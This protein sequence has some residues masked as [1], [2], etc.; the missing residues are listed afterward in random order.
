MKIKHKKVAASGIEVALAGILGVGALLQTSVSVQASSAMMPGIEEIVSEASADKPFKILEIVDD[1]QDAEIG[2]YVSGQEPYI[3]LYSYTYT[4]KDENNTKQEK[5]IHFSSLKEGLQKLPDEQSRKE[6]AMNVKLNEAGEIDESASTGIKD[7]RSVCGDSAESSPLS[8]SEY[9]EKYFLSNDDNKD[10]WKT[11]D[12]IEVETGETRIDT[13]TLT[14]TYQENSAGTGNYTK[15]EQEYY[16]IRKGNSSDA[17]RTDKYRENIQNFYYSDG[18][19]NGAP[20]FLEFEP[21]ENSYINNA[22]DNKTQNET[23]GPEYDYSKG[24]YGYY[25]NVYADLTEDMVTDIGNNKYTFPGENP[26]KISNFDADSELVQEYISTQSDAFSAGEENEFSSVNTGDAASASTG[27]DF[28]SG[29]SDGF[30]DGDF[31]TGENDGIDDV[32]GN[33]SVQ[34]T[35]QGSTSVEAAS[36][37]IVPDMEDGTA[38]QATILGRIDNPTAQTQN[39]QSDPNVYIGENIDEY[40]YYKYTLVGD[41]EYIKSKAREC[42]DSDKAAQEA[43][44]SIQRQ[45]GDITI[46]NGQYW[47]WQEKS[48]KSD[49]E[50][51]TLSVVTGR[52][53]VAYSDIKKIDSRVTENY[54]YRVTKVYFCCINKDSG[55]K[56]DDFQYFGWYYPSYPQN[57][58]PYIKVNQGEKATHYISEA[59]Y[60]LTPGKG[61]YD[62]VPGGEQ[63]NSVEV[64]HIY[65]KGGYKNNDWFKRYVFHLSPADSDFDNF[66]IEVDTK[67]A[68]KF[69]TEYGNGTAVASE[70]NTAAAAGSEGNSANENNEIEDSNSEDS[71]DS[72]TNEGGVSEVAPMTSEAGVELVSIE[73]EINDSQTENF[74]D[75]TDTEMNAEEMESQQAEVSVNDTQDVEFSDGGDDVTDAFSAGN[76][77]NTIAV[78]DLADYDLIYINSSML[79]KASMT[80]IASLASTKKLPCIINETKLENNADFAEAFSEFI[81][82]EDADKHYV[83]TCVYF[84][85]NTLQAENPSDLLNVLFDTNFNPDVEEGAY[86]NADQTEGFE[87]IIKYIEKENKYREIG[88][89]TISDGSQTDENGKN[90]NELSKKLSQ[91]RA[92]EYIINYKYKRNDMPTGEIRVLE[93]QPARSSGKITNDDVLS[94]LGYSNKITVSSCCN[95]VNEIPDN[96]LNKNNF[97]WHSAYASGDKIN[98][99]S[100]HPMHWFKMEFEKETDIDGF[101]YIARPTGKNGILNEYKVEFYDKNG[102]L[103]ENETQTGSMGY[104]WYNIDRSSK[105]IIFGNKVKNVKSMKIIFTKT[106]GDSHANVYATASYIAPVWE[107]PEINITTMTTSEFVGHIDD[108]NTKYDMVYLGDDASDLNY[109]ANFRPDKQILYYHIGGSRLAK[110][111]LQGLMNHDYVINSNGV[112]VANKVGDKDESTGTLVGSVRGSGND[113]TEQ[114]KNKLVDFAKSGYPVIVAGDIYDSNKSISTDLVDNS[115]YIYDFLNEIKGYDNVYREKDI[116]KEDDIAFYAELPKPK[117]EFASENGKPVSAIGTSDGPSG[118]YMSGDNITFNFQIIDEAQASPANASYDCE[119]Y[120]DL[121]CDGNYSKSEKLKD[122]IVSKDGEVV[123]ADEDGK[124]HLSLKT[125]YTVS[126]K[127]PEEYIKLMPWKLVVTNNSNSEIRTSETGYTKRQ[128]TSAGNNTICVLQ[129][130]PNNSCNWTLSTDTEFKNLFN[131]V[132]EDFDV[133]IEAVTISQYEAS[134]RTNSSYLD[135][136]NMLIIGFCDG[137]A[138]GQDLGNGGNNFSKNGAQ[139]IL[140]F[141]NTGKSVIFAHDNTSSSNI[142]RDTNNN[143]EGGLWTGWAYYFNKI[144][145]SVSG[146]DRYGITESE[147][148]EILKGAKILE[149]GTDDWNIISQN[150]YDMAYELGSGKTKAYSETQGFS[151]GKLQIAIQGGGSDTPATNYVT[152]INEGAISEYPYKID[153]TFQ[154]ANTH[155]QYYQL[156]MEED[157]DHDGSSD[158]V[159]WYC[160]GNNGTSTSYYDRTPNDVRNNYYIYSYK[161][162]IYTGVGHS[163]GITSMEKKLF[164]NTIIAAYNA[165]AVNP[166]LSFVKSSDWN[167]AQEKSVYYMLD[168]VNFNESQELVKDS[169]DFHLKVTDSNLVGT[170]INGDATKDLKLE[171]FIESDSVNAKTIDGIGTNTRVEKIEVPISGGQLSTDAN[172]NTYVYSG[173]V[174]DFTLGNL[175]KYL[176][177]RTEEFR[178]KTALYARISCKYLYYGVEKEA[179][180]VTKIDI[181]Q[182]QLFDMD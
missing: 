118:N 139:R 59:E 123:K 15:G 43:G 48:D 121:N 119:L 11:A 22:I 126:R 32:S 36:D 101:I 26:A 13:V 117:I 174:Y 160:L 143:S 10:E 133:Q 103:M 136:Y 98:D 180:S 35:E 50:K 135:A 95:H 145:R 108:V 149:S 37:V 173:N 30:S 127:V 80:E 33:S 63:I 158:I 177:D 19:E 4:Y 28:G 111:E 3:K 12:F 120:I 122:I 78:S 31:S 54:Y 29:Q 46:E 107:E 72:D 156:A 65:Y 21:V 57:E 165:Q 75:G 114:I 92:I 110:Y 178:G 106:F 150:T 14:G 6:F 181:C 146:M 159:V 40:P 84:F 129:I 44:Q 115:S 109:D 167:A 105:K 162:V 142:D 56:S 8:M 5:T 81:N 171:L 154:V 67:T 164:V 27:S 82:N 104:D 62:F 23:I 97:I 1:T 131:A 172:G 86:A 70:E 153:S 52:Q 124:Y 90:K 7:I 130:T 134:L 16:P 87:E 89:D 169:Q 60:K 51:I 83:N 73:N 34:T 138:Y 41:L 77:D 175:Q 140:D 166:E 88:G 179:Q 38:E 112:K 91:S 74:Q 18:E 45:T 182:R 161:N 102:D 100:T 125:F 157:S 66:N 148:S 113:I 116:E 49:F 64:D 39:Y 155:M 20:Y 128:N 69:N 85:K 58:E 79:N 9:E 141:A 55:E 168:N 147:T 42:Q 96:V 24:R 17:S 71:S 151:N 61:N 163:S 99:S 170:S 144:L 25:E 137:D 53:P 93:L 94:W 2:Y 176:K 132:K 47:Y 76:A 152:N 68:D